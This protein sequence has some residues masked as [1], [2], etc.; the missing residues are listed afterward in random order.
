[1]GKTDE[2]VTPAQHEAALKRIRELEASIDELW[3]A[4]GRNLS[5]NR[6][7]KPAE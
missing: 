2:H 4:L 7:E 6:P 1:M 3:L 5:V